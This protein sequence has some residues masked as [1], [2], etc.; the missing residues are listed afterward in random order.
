MK[1]RRLNQE[2][3]SQLQKD[4]IHF[5]VANG[6]PGPEWEKLKTDDPTKASELIDLFSDIIFDQTLEKIEYLEFKT[7][8]DIKTFS[9]RE[10]K[11]ILNGL[12]IEGDTD[13]DFTQS[14]DPR[15]MAQLLAG[16]R[17]KLQLYTAQKEYYPDRKQELFQ[18][19]ENGALISRDG[20]LFKTLE[21]LKGENLKDQD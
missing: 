1:Y 11:I 5:L 16:S 7:S 10:H 17:A 15:E 9:C 13:I 14:Q 19:M 6:I 12:K 2:E 21:A 3:L 4:F 18:M 8:K 20:S